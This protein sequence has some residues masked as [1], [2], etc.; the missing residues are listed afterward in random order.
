ML[1]ALRMGESWPWASDPSPFPFLFSFPPAFQHTYV[2]VR[3][4]ARPRTN[5]RAHARAHSDH[6]LTVKDLMAGFRNLGGSGEEALAGP[7]E[8]LVVPFSKAFWRA[9]STGET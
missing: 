8:S 2:R 9:P 5:V 4:H 6:A 1:A 7:V 3:T